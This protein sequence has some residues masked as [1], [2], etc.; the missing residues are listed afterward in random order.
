[1]L[2]YISVN[3]LA[4]T[5][6]AN[7]HTQT[8]LPKNRRRRLN[9]A[10]KEIPPKPSTY[11]CPLCRVSCLPWLIFRNLIKWNQVF[12]SRAIRTYYFLIRSRPK[13]RKKFNNFGS[14]PL[15]WPILIL[16]VIY[17]N[18]LNIVSMARGDNSRYP[19]YKSLDIRLIS[20]YY[21]AVGFGK[22]ILLFPAIFQVFYSFTNALTEM[23]S[24]AIF[25]WYR[26]KKNVPWR[27]NFCS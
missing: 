24:D 23:F 14:S 15:F 6:Q 1:M 3:W 20:G 7:E 8:R 2:H 5:L 25:F 12:G 27:K 17:S 16:D 10:A 22:N 19:V 4:G 18:L 13:P 21:P 26:E 9:I 11:D